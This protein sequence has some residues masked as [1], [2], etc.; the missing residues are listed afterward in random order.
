MRLE[1]QAVLGVQLNMQYGILSDP[2]HPSQEKKGI[3]I[4]D[5]KNQWLPCPLLKH[6]SAEILLN[7]RVH[8]CYGIFQSDRQNV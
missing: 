4:L 5:Q 8:G 1:K 6:R 7:A 3:L 2:N